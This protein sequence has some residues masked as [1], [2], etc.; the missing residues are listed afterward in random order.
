[1]SV[2]ENRTQ[3]GLW[4]MLAAPLI[5]STN[6]TKLSDENLG[7]IGNTGAIAIDQDPLG[8]Q[9]KIVRED[10]NH[11]IVVKPL[12]HQRLALLIANISSQQHSYE[13]SLADI[14]APKLEWWRH[15]ALEKVFAH[16]AYG[17]TNSTITATV[18]SH[19]VAL[20]VLTPTNNWLLIV[21][22]IIGLIIIIGFSVFYTIK[23]MRRK[24][25]Q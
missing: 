5:I 10:K 14:L 22:L 16:E 19:D 20:L 9:G 8:V 4:A 3:M 23:L 7:I 21:K 18:S 11:I 13:I 17:G 2:A 24:F 12:V 6:L 25:S 1:M 15:Y